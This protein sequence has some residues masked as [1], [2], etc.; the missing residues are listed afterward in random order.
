MATT[1][2]KKRDLGYA[3]RDLEAERK[4]YVE[5]HDGSEVGRRVKM[6]LTCLLYW[7]T[8]NAYAH[9]WVWHYIFLGEDN[10]YYYCDTTS[11]WGWRI[12]ENATCEWS[13]IVGDRDDKEDYNGVRIKNLH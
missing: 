3:V 1:T 10:R 6:K 11:E 9:G 4:K 13:F 5:E 2:T 8:K 7:H 12:K